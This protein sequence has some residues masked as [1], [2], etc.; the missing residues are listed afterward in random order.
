MTLF[1]LPSEGAPE[2]VLDEVRRYTSGDRFPRVEGRRTLAVHWH[3]AYTDQA[4]AKGMDWV[5]PFK[6]VLRDMGV[7]AALIKDF[8]GD[9]HPRD[10]TDLRLQELDAGATHRLVVVDDEDQ[11]FRRL[12]HDEGDAIMKARA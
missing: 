1:L 7:D 3:V 5:P 8:H 9:G 2:A 4:L 12:T 11:G 10:T 6:P